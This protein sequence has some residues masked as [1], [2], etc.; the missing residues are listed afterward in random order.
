MAT[1]IMAGAI[2]SKLI[3][4]SAVLVSEPSAERRE[5]LKQ[6]YQ[7]SVSSPDALK[8]E[9]G[10]ALL[11][12]VKP[13]LFAKVCEGLK[14]QIPSNFLTI[15][16]M[17]G[18]T[19]AGIE[20]AV[21]EGA[22]VVRT[23][24]NTAALVQ[25][26]ATAFAS[27]DAATVEDRAFVSALFSS[28]GIARE[29]SESQLNAVTG[30]SGSGPAYVL[31]FIEALADAGVSAGLYRQDAVAL[32]VETVLGTAKMVKESG[33]HTGVLRD[34]V[35]SPGGTTIHG[36]L[37]LERGSFRATVMNAVRAAKQR[38]EEMG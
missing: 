17:A 5:E 6:R 28:V 7:V 23:M 8:L 31:T 16:V 22:R 29:V 38:A 11:L 4:P 32:A 24:P 36:V 33:Q 20:N 13:Q 26:G 21:G 14:S 12:A 2:Q 15:S 35:T 10:D 27:S 1:A 30:L 18:V 3:S 25:A 19:I 34:Q 37:E 9:E